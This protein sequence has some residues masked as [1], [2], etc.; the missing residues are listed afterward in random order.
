MSTQATATQA[1]DAWKT[2][3]NNDEE[4]QKPRPSGKTKLPTTPTKPNN[5]VISTITTTTTNTTTT[6]TIQETIT[7][8]RPALGLPTVGFPTSIK[9]KTRAPQNLKPYLAGPGYG[10]FYGS[11]DVGLKPGTNS[12]RQTAWERHN[13][14]KHLKKNIRKMKPTFSTQPKVPYKVTAKKRK[15]V[16]ALVKAVPD[17]TSRAIRAASE[18]REKMVVI[19]E[20]EQS[21]VESQSMTSHKKKMIVKK[22]QAAVRYVANKWSVPKLEIPRLWLEV[23]LP[24]SDGIGSRT[25]FDQFSYVLKR[26]CRHNIQAQELLAAYLERRCVSNE[27]LT[28]NEINALWKLAVMSGALHEDVVFGWHAGILGAVRI[29]ASVEMNLE[30]REQLRV[31][32]QPFIKWLQRRESGEESDRSMG[33]GEGEEVE[34][35]ERSSGGG[36]GVP[37]LAL[38]MG[39]GRGGGPFTTRNRKKRPIQ[40]KGKKNNNGTGPRERRVRSR[41]QPKTAR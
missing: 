20:L 9:S 32:M 8:L 17:P 28:P 30:R 6:N 24:E 3:P 23:V 16:L 13:N 18:L 37:Q 11:C 35:G 29:V 26:E 34:K 39:D 31:K 2:T 27:S 12:L 25:R 33:G 21:I 36:N 1:Q 5:T 19:Q 15:R 4:N 14:D 22:I 38:P 40:P 10:F 41:A 7:D